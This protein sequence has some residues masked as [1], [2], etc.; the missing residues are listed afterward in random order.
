MGYK[1]IPLPYSCDFPNV[2]ALDSSF[3]QISCV[4]NDGKGGEE[5]QTRASECNVVRAVVG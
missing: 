2:K 4:N 5:M 3:F 1:T